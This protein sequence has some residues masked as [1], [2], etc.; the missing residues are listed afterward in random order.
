[1]HSNMAAMLPWQLYVSYLRWTYKFAGK[2]YEIRIFLKNQ[3]GFSTK[4]SV[5]LI[6]IW[7]CHVFPVARLLLTAE[8]PQHLPSCLLVVLANPCVSGLQWKC[9]K[10][11]SPPSPPRKTVQIS[12][13]ADVQPSLWCQNVPFVALKMLY[14]CWHAGRSSFSRVLQNARIST[15]W[16]S[17]SVSLEDNDISFG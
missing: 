8:R 10:L 16:P 4:M 3:R 17:V 6:K 5:K 7:L 9:S 1:M 2:N 12:V 11:S 13:V 15:L 14:A